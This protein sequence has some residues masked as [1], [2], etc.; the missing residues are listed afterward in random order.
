MPIREAVVAGSVS[1]VGLQTPDLSAAKQ[2]YGSLFGWSFEGGEDPQTGFYSF[3]KLGGKNVAGLA[4]LGP[5]SSFPPMW[6]VYLTTDSAD[7]TAA[8]VKSA[9]GT[10]VA[11]PLEV[12]GEGRM[13]YF[14][15]PA[16]AW[17]GVWQP[18]RHRGAELVGE[19]GTMVW[20]E[21][22]SRDASAARTFYAR[23]F[24]LELKPLDAP[25]IDYATLHVGTEVSFGLMQMP[26][27][28]EKAMP[29]HWNTYFAVEDADVSAQKAAALGG[30]IIAPPFDTP[31]GRLVFAADPFG[32]RFCLMKPARLPNG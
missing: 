8:K 24:G 30:K 16:G 3:A 11:A 13:A 26:E 25:G 20:H 2:F 9:G 4:K 6:S 29:S 12:M 22:Y 5:D 19:P 23:V 10:I 31:Y 18:G 32:A 15:D 14:T 21:S 27:H 28:Y 17:F 7:E 1:W